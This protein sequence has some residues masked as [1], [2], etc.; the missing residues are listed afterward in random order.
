MDSRPGSFKV[1]FVPYLTAA[2]LFIGGY[3]WGF[4]Y[5]S[6]QPGFPAS[7]ETIRIW[8]PIV[9][10]FIPTLLL[11]PLALRLVHKES[12]AP[13][14][15]NL[16]FS[17]ALGMA[18][19]PL[20]WGMGYDLLYVV[21]AF[22]L[23]MVGVV[24]LLRQAAVKVPA[25][26]QVP[27]S[28]NSP[29]HDAVPVHDDGH[30]YSHG[31]N[32]H[33]TPPPRF[34]PRRRAQ[35]ILYNFVPR[36][37]YFVT[38]ILIDI[39]VVVFLLMSWQARSIFSYPMEMLLQWGADNGPLV[40]AGQYWRVLT[41]TFLHGGGLIHIFSNMYALMFAGIVLE[42]V[43]GIRR[44]TFMYLMAG[45]VASITSIVVHWNVVGTGASGAVFGM[46]GGLIALMVGKIPSP[47]LDRIAMGSM[48]FFVAYN[49]A[50]GMIPGID[51]AAHIGGLV[52][53]F[54]IGLLYLPGLR[55]QDRLQR[56]R[57]YGAD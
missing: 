11:R 9:L 7:S 12:Q 29:Y 39:N 48:V 44:Y 50:F 24:Y 17:S 5:L 10:V 49:L 23:G 4:H 41:S 6:Q 53:G 51:N 35:N 14:T 55:K 47:H 28:H 25:R 18:L 2:I 46:Y 37:G 19:P 1:Y 52:T 8:A 27:I 54:L 38:P 3:F 21:L 42:P 43:L 20:L 15:F 36:Q 34:Q 31:T 56:Q 26:T 33:S 13:L 32:G 40:V 16:L 22:V 30:A 57:I 45:I